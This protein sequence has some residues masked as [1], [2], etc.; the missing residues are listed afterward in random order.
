ME[1]MCEFM[2]DGNS[3]FNRLDDKIEPLVFPE[4]GNWR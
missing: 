4:F 2:E 3:V 1:Y